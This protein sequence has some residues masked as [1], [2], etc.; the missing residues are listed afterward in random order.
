MSQRLLFITKWVFIAQWSYCA[1][2][3]EELNGILGCIDARNEVI[4]QLQILVTQHL[5]CNNAFI[6]ETLILGIKTKNTSRFYLVGKRNNCI[7]KVKGHLRS[8][9]YYIGKHMLEVEENV[10]AMEV[11]QCCPNN[12]TA[13]FQPRPK[14]HTLIKAQDHDLPILPFLL[15]CI[16][17]GLMLKH[18][19]RERDLKFFPFVCISNTLTN[20][21]QDIF[22]ITIWLK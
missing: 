6:A 3:K 12:L 4:G 11:D 14:L 8:R 18:K 1:N 19:K 16:Q 21:F 2:V 7:D 15:P 20:H 5:F 13:H 22:I 9:K 17:D 10:V